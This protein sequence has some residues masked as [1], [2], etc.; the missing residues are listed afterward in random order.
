MQMGPHQVYKLLHIKGNHKENE[1][2][3]MDW[4]KVFANDV[5]VTDKGLTSKI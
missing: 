1:R 3:P 4:K 5:N 2:Q